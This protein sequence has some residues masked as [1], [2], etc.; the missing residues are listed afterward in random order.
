MHADRRA[1]HCTLRRRLCDTKSEPLSMG[2]RLVI[3]TASGRALDEAIAYPFDQGRLVIGRGSSA[4]VR[5]PHLTVSAVHAT[6]AVDGDGY[7]LIDQGSTNGTRVN[8]E[9]LVPGRRKLLKDGDRL[10]IGAYTL[11]FHAGELVTQP[12]TAERTAELARR[13]FRESQGTRVVAPARLIVLDG[14]AVGARLDIPGAPARL[15]IGR[16][17]HCQLVLADPE[18]AREHMEVVHDLDGIRIRPIEGSGG[19]E[20]EGEKIVVRRLRDG[21]EL[22]LGA[23]RLLF[24]EPAEEPMQA[25]GAEPDRTLRAR[26]SDTTDAPTEPKPE[27]NDNASAALATEPR[28]ALGDADL[29]IYAIATVVVA[30]S[31]AGL[32]ILMRAG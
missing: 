16:A 31:I 21:D 13:L 27:R 20:I 17:E 7:T 12:I 25:L 23:T 4:D 29:V 24:E 11:S 9:A 3:R 19:V 2:A 15:L 22:K 30:A 14:P 32:V 6:L 18:V 5:I 1:P 8:G 28:S 26:D 10:D